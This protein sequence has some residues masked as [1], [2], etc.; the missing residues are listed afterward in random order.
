MAYLSGNPPTTSRP[1]FQVIFV[2]PPGR[3]PAWTVWF[4]VPMVADAFVVGKAS[5]SVVYISGD[6]R[7]TLVDATAQFVSNQY[8]DLSGVRFHVAQ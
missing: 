5:H 1:N 8:W 6:G 4:S 2:L 3:R 7:V